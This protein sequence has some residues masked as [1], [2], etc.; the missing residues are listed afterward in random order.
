MIEK[1]NTNRICIAKRIIFG[2]YNN[3]QQYYNNSFII[4]EKVDFTY[5]TNNYHIFPLKYKEIFDNIIKKNKNCSYIEWYHYS[6]WSCR[7]HNDFPKISLV[8]NHTIINMHNIL[9]EKIGNGFPALIILFKDN[10]DTIELSVQHMTYKGFSVLFDDE[11]N[12]IKFLSNV[13]KDIIKIDYDSDEYTNILLYV[14]IALVLIVIISIIFNGLFYK[15]KKVKYE[16]ISSVPKNENNI[17]E[18]NK[19]N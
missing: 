15:K 14:I 18:E 12:I 16:K 11:N 8:I 6:L 2:K 13:T 7:N 9:I 4:N 10:I 1:Y 17:I 5:N 19:L 3:V